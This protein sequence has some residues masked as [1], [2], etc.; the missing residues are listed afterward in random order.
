MTLA[1]RLGQATVV[2]VVV[3]WLI[4]RAVCLVQ[5]RRAVLER[6]RRD[7]LDHLRRLQEP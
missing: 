3:A 7:F 5:R 4:H 2:V 1:A 6:Q